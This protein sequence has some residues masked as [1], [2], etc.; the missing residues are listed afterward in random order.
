[1][2]TMPHPHAIRTGVQIVSETLQFC[3]FLCQWHLLVARMHGHHAIE[4]RATQR[5][6]G[7][8]CFDSKPVRMENAWLC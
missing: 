1:M 2:E 6:L 8:I 3:K 4:A 5:R 7:R